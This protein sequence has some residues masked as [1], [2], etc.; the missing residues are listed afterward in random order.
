MHKPKKWALIHL[1]P[2]QLHHKKSRKLA[3]ATSNNS[4][5]IVASNNTVRSPRAKGYTLG[6]CAR[7]QK[8]DPGLLP[9][10]FSSCAQITI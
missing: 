1:L 9:G 6:T 8:K 5:C 3:L 2:L 10:S 4:L 7:H